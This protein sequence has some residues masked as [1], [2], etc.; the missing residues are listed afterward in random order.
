MDTLS[1]IATKTVS[2]TKLA[3]ATLV[4]IVAG[5]AAF[6]AAPVSYSGCVDFD[7][8][9]TFDQNQLFVKSDTT[10]NIG[11]KIDSCYTFPKTGKTY[12]MEG[13]CNAKATFATWQKNCADLNYG[14]SGSD[15]KC[16]DGACVDVA[17]ASVNPIGAD[18][19]ELW[20]IDTSKN[21]QLENSGCETDDKVDQIIQQYIT[22]N[23][24]QS[25]EEQIEG[26]KVIFLIPNNLTIADPTIKGGIILTK[27]WLKYAQKYFGK[28]PCKKLYILTYGSGPGGAGASPGS[29][30]I[31]GFGGFNDLYLLFHEL[32]HSYFW[33]SQTSQTAWL[34]EGPSSAIFLLMLSDIY[35]EI[36][37]NITDFPWMP[38]NPS[39]ANVFLN[40]FNDYFTPGSLKYENGKV[41][42]EKN[43][44]NLEEENENNFETTHEI[45]GS[46]GKLLLV[47]LAIK[48]GKQTVIDA[49]HAVYEKYRYTNE[50]ITDM[51]FY[52]AFLY[53]MAKKDKEMSTNLYV[54]AKQFLDVKLCQQQ[55]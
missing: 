27:S 53:Y 40:S 7:A 10:Y 38:P 25:I 8:K 37:W 34:A 30:Y 4:M 9:T 28:F 43:S 1:S 12:L 29:V 46:W 49:L 51:D 44:C 52:K 6:V 33:G 23:N 3:I 45:N 16:V 14:K 2:N 47:D 15:F 39:T 36:S 21:K 31:G 24:Y 17:V 55:M 13:T 22:V 11:K 35:N 18:L 48:F 42:L 50:K 41:Y 19:Y 54:E 5:G 20:G 32:T 26:V